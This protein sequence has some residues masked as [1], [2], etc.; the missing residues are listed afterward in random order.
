MNIQ[1][2]I[3]TDSRPSDRF[4]VPFETLP[5]PRV[6]TELRTEIT[7]LQRKR[8]PEL[9]TQCRTLTDAATMHWS[10]CRRT[11]TKTIWRS[12]EQR[13]TINLG[14]HYIHYL[15]WAKKVPR[16]F[17][18]S[19]QIHLRHRHQPNGRLLKTRRSSSFDVMAESGEMLLR[20][21]LVAVRQAVDCDTKTISSVDLNGMRKSRISLRFCTTGMISQT[22]C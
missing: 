17:Q 10:P 9:P 19:G 7:T 1:R 4:G 16:T 5:D 3:N 11:R 6:V 21:C 20:S 12:D 8:S 15:R 22:R 14:G 2:L 18:Q 13:C